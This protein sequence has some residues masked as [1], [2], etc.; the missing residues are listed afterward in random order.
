MDLIKITFQSHPCWLRMVRL[1]VGEVCRA[2]KFSKKD[3]SNLVLAVD[4]ACANVIRHNYRGRADGTIF[5]NCR[6]RKGGLEFVLRDRGFRMNCK[7][8]EHRSLD[9]VRP[10]GL[11]VF[12]IKKMMDEVSYRRSG[13]WNVVKM[14]K[15]GTKK[16]G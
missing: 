14:V 9:K 4:E 1:V 15:Y 12:F 6:F 13:K 8:I 5:L 2:A 7:K 3:I 16:S 11:G 10:G